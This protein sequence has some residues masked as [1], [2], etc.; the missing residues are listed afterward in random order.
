MSGLS[1]TKKRD[2]YDKIARLAALNGEVKVRTARGSPVIEQLSTSIA[3]SHYLFRIMSS[4]GKFSHRRKIQKS[5]YPGPF[6]RPP[7]LCLDY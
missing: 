5:R 3:A 2:D 6:L 7:R 1:E 4:I